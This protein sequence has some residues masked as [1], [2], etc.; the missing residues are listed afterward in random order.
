MVLMRIIVFAIGY[1]GGEEVLFDGGEDSDKTSKIGG[2]FIRTA[3]AVYVF[4][5]QE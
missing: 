4:P 5:Y 2:L 3:K 1:T